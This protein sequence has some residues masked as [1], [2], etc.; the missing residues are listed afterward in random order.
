MRDML[1]AAA[2]GLALALAAT[3]A[4]AGGA[5]SPGFSGSGGRSTAVS[6]G[7]NRRGDFGNGNHRRHRR[8]GFDGD[9]IVGDWGGGDW[10]LYN[11]R[12]FEPDSYNDW[13]HDRPDRAYPRWVTNG[14]CDRMWWGGDTLRCTW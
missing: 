9:I 7:T 10:A 2:A 13:W 14:S 1:F 4:Q 12:T 11:N 8:G 3:P 6:G 5:G